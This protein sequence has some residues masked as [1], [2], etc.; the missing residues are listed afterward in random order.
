MALRNL[1]PEKL[2]RELKNSHPGKGL[3]GE[4][5]TCSVKGIPFCG[6]S[7]TNMKPVI[8][9][10]LDSPHLLHE[11]SPTESEHALISRTLFNRFAPKALPC[12]PFPGLLPFPPEMVWERGQIL[13]TQD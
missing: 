1:D 5:L 7:E 8:W 12:P 13:V 9:V 6:P 3:D 2:T 10:P 11:V 4:L